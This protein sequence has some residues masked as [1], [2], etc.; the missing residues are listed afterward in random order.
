MLSSQKLPHLGNLYS[1]FSLIT[2]L[3]NLLLH[4]LM[5]L[6]QADLCLTQKSGVMVPSFPEGELL[7]YFNKIKTDIRE[8]KQSVQEVY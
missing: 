5:L 7:I 3:N 8:G 6:L 2:L 4:V 1:A